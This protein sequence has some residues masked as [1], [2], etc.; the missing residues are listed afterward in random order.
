MNRVNTLEHY[1]QVWKEVQ[2]VP[3][4]R[5]T[6][7]GDHLS[8]EM[9]Y[10]MAGPGGIEKSSTDEVDHLSLCSECLEKWASWRRAITVVAEFEKINAGEENAFP[11]ITYGLREA[12][13]SLASREPVS[14]RSSCGKFV[15]SLLPQVDNPDKGLVTIEA[16]ADGTMSV[17]GRHFIVRDRNGIVV[18][19]GK[20]HHGRLARACDRLTDFDL[21][22][23][24][25]A[26]NDKADEG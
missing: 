21:S 23:W 26:V 3:S 17:E 1:L 11:L 18:L 20:L 8:M 10:R 12:A 4:E 24:T 15:L 13:A 22:A 14:M 5:G 7:Q 16:A 25:L 19:E 6:G 9:L 2:S